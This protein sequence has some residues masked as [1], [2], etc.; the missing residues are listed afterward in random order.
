MD[1]LKNVE[2]N[3]IGLKEQLDKLKENEA[4]LFIEETAE[5]GGEGVA[6]TV[7]VKS[8]AEHKPGKE[9]DYDKM[10]DDDYYTSIFKK[11]TK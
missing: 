2:G 5:D 6:T 7:R 4:Y 10:S 8:G 1:S 9:T 3:I 11:D